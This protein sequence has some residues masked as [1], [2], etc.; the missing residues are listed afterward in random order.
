MTPCNI[1]NMCRL[2]EL[3]LIAVSD[4]NSI[5][6]VEAVMAAASRVGIT[7]IPAMEVE[8]VEEIHIL[9]LFPDMHSAQTIA[10]MVYQALPNIENREEIFGQQQYLDDEDRV[11]DI[12][13]KL[14]ISPTTLSAE[15][16]FDRV[17][18]VGGIAVPAHVDRH[19]YSILTNLGMIPPELAV[20]CI[21]ISR[22][23]ADVEAYLTHRPEL[24]D[25]AILQNSDAH[26]LE[27]LVVPPSRLA[28]N[29]TKAFWEYCR[30]GK[31]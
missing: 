9:T 7:V 26:R 8:T 15:V 3:D 21:E 31:R 27:S 29:D 5:G 20:S 17:Y 1:V 23:T 25:Y 10:D 2:M 30:G 28:C 4:H 14:L 11:L 6:N 12:E 22:T 18:T 24:L 13:K 19:S 16:L